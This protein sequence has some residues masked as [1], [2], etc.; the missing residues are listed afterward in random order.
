MTPSPAI[1]RLINESTELG[2]HMNDLG[3]YMQAVSSTVSAAE[4]TLL[5]AQAEVMGLYLT[6]LT[7]RLSLASGVPLK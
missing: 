1:M 6:L 3:K 7:A 2:S 4:A 5:Q